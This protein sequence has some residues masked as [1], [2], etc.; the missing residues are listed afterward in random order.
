[1]PAKCQRVSKI[2]SE[3]PPVSRDASL[4]HTQKRWRFSLFTLFVT[5]TVAAIASCVVSAYWPRRRPFSPKIGITSLSEHSDGS[6]PER[7]R[8][9]T[10][11]RERGRRETFF[12]F[13][14]YGTLDKYTHEQ[15]GAYLEFCREDKSRHPF[16]SQHSL[17]PAHERNF[18][19]ICRFIE[20]Q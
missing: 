5:V 18:E 17:T 1:M 19:K 14:P 20:L 15:N 13:S 8:I 7:V 16:P 4:D 3:N 9:Y 2:R 12:D 6:S 11:S 10:V